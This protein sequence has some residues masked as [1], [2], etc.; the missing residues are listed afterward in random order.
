MIQAAEIEIKEY[1][2]QENLPEKMFSLPVS[3]SP[4]VAPRI[5]GIN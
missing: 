1:L 5:P 4:E 2:M 3:F